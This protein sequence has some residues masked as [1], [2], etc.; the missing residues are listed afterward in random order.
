MQL[1]AHQPIDHVRVW[2]ESDAV[3]RLIV[4]DGLT[5]RWSNGAALRL[6]ER[7]GGFEIRGGKLLVKE[8]GWSEDFKSFVRSSDARISTSCVRGA[9]GEHSLCTAM[10]LGGAAGERLTGLTLRSTAQTPPLASAALQAAFR[11]TGAERRIVEQLFLGG[12][13]EEVGTRLRV[14]IGTVRV[15]IRHVYDK[16]QVTSREAMFSKLA[17]FI[18]TQ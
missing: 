2:V 6:I 9:E 3:P 17:P 12:T 16:L 15:H 13:A 8:S 18:L 7:A 5:V 1:T 4:S 10:R 11:L 14:S